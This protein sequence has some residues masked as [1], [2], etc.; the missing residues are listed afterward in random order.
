M[1]FWQNLCRS[2]GIQLQPLQGRDPPVRSVGKRSGN[3]RDVLQEET[4]EGVNHKL[5]AQTREASR[6]T[7]K[8]LCQSQQ[9]HFTTDICECHHR[10]SVNLGFMKTLPTSPQSA[11]PHFKLENATKAL[12]TGYFYYFYYHIYYCQFVR[13]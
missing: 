9:R 13:I 3:P 11:T 5:W 2:Q 10:A 4:R 12:Q 1:V 7:I 8:G 6:E